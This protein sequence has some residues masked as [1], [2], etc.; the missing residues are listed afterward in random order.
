[1]KV[2]YIIRNGHVY[3]PLNGVNEIRDVYVKN[4]H[5]VDP[6]GED[7]EC[8]ADFI[9]DATG[10]IVTPGLIDFHTH[11]FHEGSSICIHPDMMIAQGT[12]SAVDAG[13]AG[14]STYPAFYKSVIAQSQVRVKGFLTVYGGGQLDPK[15]CEDFNPAL[16]NVEKMERVIEANKDNILGLKIRLSKGVVP[17]ETGADYLRAVV[18]LADELNEKLGTSLRVCVH[19]TNSPVPAGELAECLRPGDIFCHCFQGAGNTIVG[20]DGTIDPRVLEARERGVIFDAAN[21]KGNFGIK[22]AQAALAAGFLPDIIST[23]LTV[24]KFNM[25]PYAKNLPLVISKYLALGM[26]LMTILERVT[27]VPAR[28]MGMEGKIGTLQEGAFADIAIF[29]LKEKEYIQKDFCDDEILCGQILV[30]QLT[31][32]DGEIQYCQSDF[33]L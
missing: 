26:D 32:I 20:E 2:D 22:T 18:K 11:L 23:D 5:I 24:D 6:K 10:K 31:M 16:F 30:P 33:Y 8:K 28:L 15:L 17:D 13:S 19:T 14:T 27:V 3:D 4:M 29:E 21:G 12:T 25:P 1:M 9:I 7:V